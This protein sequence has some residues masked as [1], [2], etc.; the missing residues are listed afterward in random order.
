MG[1][2]VA[3]GQVAVSVLG[4]EENEPLIGILE[5]RICQDEDRAKNL[6]SPCA[7]KGSLKV[8]VPLLILKKAQIPAP[9]RAAYNILCL[10]YCLHCAATGDA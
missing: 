5:C 10:F 2:L 4:K 8:R 9:Y 3:S 6:E 7:G 1:G